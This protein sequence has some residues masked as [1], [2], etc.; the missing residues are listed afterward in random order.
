MVSF[1]TKVTNCQAKSFF[2]SC[3]L[4]I[5]QESRDEALTK[6]LSSHSQKLVN[7]EH[8]SDFSPAEKNHDCF[9]SF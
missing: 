5:G 2:E 3:R 1:L 4:S 7:K 8:S 6:D 9:E